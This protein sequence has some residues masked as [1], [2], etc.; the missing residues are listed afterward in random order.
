MHELSIAMSIVE[1]ASE[2]ADRHRATRVTAIHLK[3]GPLSG[4][5]PDALASAFSLAREG[6]AVES[7]GLVFEECPITVFC[8]PC[9]KPR[10]V[11]S[12][13]QMACVECGQLSGEIL[14]GREL[15]IVALELQ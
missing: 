7:A 5:V 12:M 9:G 15:Q 1:G 8:A 4:V 3:I 6:S 13:Q 2:E 11:V 10:G 14:T